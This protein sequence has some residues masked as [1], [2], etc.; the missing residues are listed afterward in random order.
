MDSSDLLF[1]AINL[2]PAIN[3]SL[4]EKIIQ[5]NNRIHHDTMVAFKYGRQ[6]SPWEFNLRDILRWCDLIHLHPEISPKDFVDLIYLQRMRTLLDRK[7]I[8]EVFGEI[9]GEDLALNVNPQYHITPSTIQIG[10]SFLPRSNRSYLATQHKIDLLH[11]FL[12]PLENIMKCV[13]MGWMCILTGST[14]SGKTSIV[15][16]LAQLTRNTLYEFAMNTGVDTTELLG[17]YFKY[18]FLTL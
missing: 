9:F 10:S 4:I 14:A 2:Y 3:P 15:R 8:I 7:Y 17:N 6:G 5:F 12:N 13:E 18:H 11:C 1:I 16:L